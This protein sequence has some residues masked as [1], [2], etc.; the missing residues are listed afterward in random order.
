MC[1]SIL[2]QVAAGWGNFWQ[3][4]VLFAGE[5]RLPGLSPMLSNYRQAQLVWTV[6]ALVA[7]MVFL[8]TGKKGKVGHWLRIS[9]LG[10]AAAPFVACFAEFFFADGIDD[11][12]DC[13]LALWPLLLLVA[14]GNAL[15]ELRKGLS[16]SRLVPFLVLAA[17]HG[18]LLSQQLWG[19]TYAIWPLLLILTTGLLAAHSDADGLIVPVWVVPALSG[20]IGA[21][22]LVCGGLYAAGHDRL[23]YLNEINGEP[24]H[25]TLPALRGLSTPGP[26]LG[27]F[28]ELVR[29]ADVEIP[30]EDGILLLPGEEPFF[31]ATG[32]TPHFPV[33]IFDRTTD[34]YS[35]DEL[36]AQADR[37]GIRWVI[38]KTRL[39][40]NE[41]PLPERER[42]MELIAAEFMVNRELAGYTAYR[43][44]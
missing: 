5:R 6:P 30:R 11:Q 27:D 26:Y 32:R 19:S 33:Q 16:L 39:Q 28:E 20:V 42:T 21:V 40:S 25:A 1:S 2:I 8:R 36:M 3:W 35:A 9:G 24:V 18:T 4:T 43:R 12:A 31:F 10:L 15:Y 44:R 7:G 17:I 23:S 14:A 13:L 34:P 37:R 29:F 22:L 38:V 41:D